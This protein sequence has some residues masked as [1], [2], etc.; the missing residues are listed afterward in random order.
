MT[1]APRRSLLVP[2]VLLGALAVATFVASFGA[3][4]LGRIEAA[5]VSSPDGAF[6]AVTSF[7]RY[8]GLIPRSPGSGGDKP[9]SLEV[10]RM[11]GRSCGRASLPM[12]S[13]GRDLQWD[14][15]STPRTA[16]VIGAA[17]WNLDACS[18][19]TSGW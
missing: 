15:T 2:G 18:L 4:L 19:D 9:G 14:L 13:I 7:R 16:T 10:L 11:D 17:T 8:E 6:V 3:F 12:V 5:K 1:D